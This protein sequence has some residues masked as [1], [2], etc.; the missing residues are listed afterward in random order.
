MGVGAL[1]GAMAARVR[2]AGEESERYFELSSQMLGI[3]T[4]DGRP[5]RLNRR[6]TEVLGRPVDELM[7]LTLPDVVH[8]D[9]L[10]VAQGDLEEILSADG[11]GQVSHT[12]RMLT[13]SGE[14]PARDGEPHPGRARRA[15]STCPPRT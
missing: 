3:F 4:L 9:D 1:C 5:V 6:W 14:R 11:D 12:V 8:P 7:A 2:K 10:P 13:A 15:C